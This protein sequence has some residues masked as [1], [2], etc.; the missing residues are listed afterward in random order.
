MLS[1][2][3]PNTAMTYENIAIVYG[4][5]GKHD[6]ALKLY[7]KAYRVFYDKFGPEHPNTKK[8]RKNMEIDYTAAKRKQP[9]DKWLAAQ[10][11]AAGAAP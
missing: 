6:E 5:Q 1:K 4:S 3:H 11:Q 7:I 2:D 10:M 9:F 8:C